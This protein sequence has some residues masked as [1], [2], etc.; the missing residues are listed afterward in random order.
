MAEKI[1]KED[2]VYTGQYITDY[3]KSVIGMLEG[4]KNEWHKVDKEFFLKLCMDRIRDVYDVEPIDY[5]VDIMIEGIEKEI[6]RVEE[7]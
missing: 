1:N 5:I 3:L 4:C 7:E 6:E 2:R